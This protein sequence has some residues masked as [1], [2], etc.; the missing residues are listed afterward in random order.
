MSGRLRTVSGCPGSQPLGGDGPA[1][2][3]WHIGLSF[4][5]PFE[6]I[7]MRCMSSLLMP[8][9]GIHLGDQQQRPVESREVQ[10]KDSRLQKGSLG[11]WA[12]GGFASSPVGVSRLP[13]PGPP[14]RRLCAELSAGLLPCAF[15]RPRRAALRARARRPRGSGID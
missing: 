4:C 6:V 15:C 5:Q 1:R 12:F 9:R 11:C 3:V 14:G 7:C 8:G 13:R 10:H 2:Y